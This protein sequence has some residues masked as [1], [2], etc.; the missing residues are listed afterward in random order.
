[1]KTLPAQAQKILGKQ[2]WNDT[3]LLDLA[4]EFIISKQHAGKEFVAFLKAKADDE[5]AEAAG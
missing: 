1:M 2:G 5:N 3:T 4:L